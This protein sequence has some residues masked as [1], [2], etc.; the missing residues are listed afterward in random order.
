MPTTAAPSPKPTNMPTV[1]SGQPSKR[2]VTKAPTSSPTK[3]PSASP[4]PGPTKQPSASPSSSVSAYLNSRLRKS[5]G[6][7]APFV[8]FELKFPSSHISSVCSFL[9]TANDSK[10]H[11]STN[12]GTNG[13]PFSS[14]DR[15]ANGQVRRAEQKTCDQRS[16]DLGS[17]ACAHNTHLQ[18]S[19]SG[20][21][22]GADLLPYRGGG[23]DAWDVRGSVRGSLYAQLW[24][25]RAG[26]K[27]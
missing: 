25:G 3:A 15:H 27:D 6:R 8:F 24:C 23:H 14:A 7:S 17:N 20:R 5:P 18:G 1:T 26:R 4:T 16:N 22:R 13:S 11:K 12:Q 21:N 9:S 10:A 19:S 2:P